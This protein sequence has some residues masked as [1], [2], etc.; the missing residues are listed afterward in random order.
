MI[1]RQLTS[2]GDWTFG[3]GAAGYATAEAAIEL[4]IKTRLL[5]WKGDCFFALD[6]FVDWY[7]RLDKGQ[8]T[9]LD[10]ELQAVIIASYGVVAI[11]SYQG[12]LNDATRAY[13][14]IANI[15]TIYG[16]SFINKLNLTAGLSPGS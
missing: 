8:K 7:G 3:K 5:S 10:F 14:G 11:N 13:Q 15:A 1:F 12:A 6:D 4:N 2:L 9:N 16:Q